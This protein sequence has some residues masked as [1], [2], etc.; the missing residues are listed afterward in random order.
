MVETDYPKVEMCS[1]GVAFLQVVDAIH[2]NFVPMVRVNFNGKNKDDFARNLK[3]LDDCITKLKLQKQISVPNMAN[4]KFQFNM[5]FLQWLYDYSQRTSPNFGTFYNGY[6]RRL[7]AYKKQNNLTSLS[8]FQI[9][10]SPHLVPNKSSYRKNEQQQDEQPLSEEEQ[11]EIKNQK[12]PLLKNINQKMQQQQQQINMQLQMQQNQQQ[13]YQNTSNIFTSDPQY[14]SDIYS[15]QNESQIP[16]K[17]IN[18]QRKTQLQDLVQSLES[19]LTSQ[20]F[21]HKMFL[22]DIQQIEEERNFYYQKLRQIEELCKKRK[23]PGPV[24]NEVVQIL[25]STPEDFIE[26]S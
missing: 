8:G 17:E 2:P 24:K 22:E 15:A 25:S 26:N 23:K 4:G 10:M 1:D 14:Q 13:Q 12:H 21:N 6:Q 11:E 19:E 16:I 20:L 3:I 7:E 5:D 9:Q 18:E